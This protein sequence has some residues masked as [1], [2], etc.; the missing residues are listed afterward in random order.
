MD[1]RISVIGAPVWLGQSRY[2]TNLAPDAIRSAGI[3]G[4]LEAAGLDVIDEGNIPVSAAGR[5]RTV[6]CNMKN[7]RSVAQSA[8]NLATAVSS[9]LAAGRFP[10]VLGGDHSVAI[11]SIAGAANHAKELGV[12][13]FDAHADINTP[14]TS[15][16][17]NIHGMPLAVSLGLGRPEL[18]DIGG[19]RGK[20]KPENLVYLGVRDIDS[21]EADRIRELGIRVYSPAEIRLRGVDTIIQEALSDLSSRCDAIHLSFD[22]DGI[23]PI[24]A[25]GVGTPVHAGVNF[26]DSLHMLTLLSASRRITSA[27]FVELNP[28]LDKDR[29]TIDATLVLISAFLAAENGALNQKTIPTVSAEAL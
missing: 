2:G 17:G 9:V 26:S 15:P 20:I 27:E 22:I 13:W 8:E 25:P 24:E 10:L 11:G 1:K 6:N 3:I 5:S 14:D 23:D 12:I 4:R 16:S 28:I 29:R 7:S 19:K 21:G 18:T